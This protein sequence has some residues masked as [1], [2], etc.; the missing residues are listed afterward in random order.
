MDTSG[1]PA[2]VTISGGVVI[3]NEINKIQEISGTN[4]LVVQGNTGEVKGDVALQGEVI[5][6]SGINVTIPS[7]SSLTVDNEAVLTN[8][9]TITNNGGL[10]T[11][12]G[13]IR[14][15]GTLP[16]G[17][18]GRIQK[19]LTADMITSVT[20][21]VYT[22]SEITPTVTFKDE[23]G[24]SDSDYE[25]S[26]EPD[27][28][29]INAKTGIKVFITPKGKFFGD[30]IE[31]TFNIDKADLKAGYFTFTAQTDDPWVY[32]KTPKTATVNFTAIGLMGAGNIALKYYKEGTALVDQ[33]IDAGTYTVK[34]DVAEGQNFK[35]AT[36]LTEDTWT[37]EIQKETPAFGEFA[38]ETYTYGT[39]TIDAPALTGVNGETIGEGITVTYH[40][41]ID[42]SQGD[43]VASPDGFPVGEHLV[44]AAFAGNDNYEDVEKQDR[45]TIEKATL[46]PSIPTG[47]QAEKGQK[48]S[49]V[50]LP[51]DPSGTWTWDV[52]ETVLGET[53]E[54]SY[55]AS[56][57]P[58]DANYDVFKTELTVKV[59]YTP[60]YFPSYYDLRFEA[61]DS[62]LFTARTTNVIE[63]SSFTFTA[64][65]AE[66]YDPATLTVE[67][68]RGR[69]GSWKTLEP[70]A[71][72]TYRIASVYDN[73][74][75]RASVSRLEDPT[76]V[77]KVEGETRVKAVGHTLYIY[78]PQEETVAVY[79]TSG[80]L[81]R[82]QRV[83]GDVS[84]ELPAG[85]YFIR[86]DGWTHKVRIGR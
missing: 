40:Q 79:T 49:A 69:N 9:G 56:F 1:S 42:I 61:N 59:V 3:A 24:V 72:G 13:I 45:F 64:E 10:F 36:N 28:D 84:F 22:G 52:P 8:E 76:A 65:A 66:G 83:T 50:K 46:S 26:Y 77:E 41:G 21:N 12:N 33:A 39:F 71:D 37:F 54:H 16:E 4:Y 70:R 38:F 82:L 67:Y 6:P 86:V 7:G 18:G 5:F 60:P 81:H 11:N 55:P 51:S 32:D 27:A 78:T 73:I 47:L 44:K 30:R 80:R 19:K 48:L 31:K 29:R 57:T 62:V 35:A 63:G 74:Y 2:T 75:V 34:I 58:T 85:I 23:S 25:L 43:W 17:T 53:G 68:K 14:N 15:S 20:G